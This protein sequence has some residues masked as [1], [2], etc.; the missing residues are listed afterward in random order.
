M[1][2]R[3]PGSFHRTVFCCDATTGRE[4][5]Q[6]AEHPDSVSQLVVTPDSKMAITSGHDGTIVF[7]EIETG[8][9][10][11]SL[12]NPRDTTGYLALSPDG[13]TLA[14]LATPAPTT[15][16]C[17]AGTS[18]LARLIRIPR[19]PR[20]T[21]D[22]LRIPFNTRR[23]DGASSLRVGRNCRYPSSFRGIKSLVQSVQS[24]A[25][26]DGGINWAEQSM[27]G[28][29]IAVATADESIFL[30]ETAT[31]KQRLQL[32]KIG[33]TTCLTLSPDGAFLPS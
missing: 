18:P 22:M 21:L 6:K 31:G 1:A 5:W 8:N 20:R 11:R 13:R 24:S 10:V 3:H 14:A 12:T 29:S 17:A 30:W 16:F 19:C 32:K 15:R 28:R 33:Y 26:M 9:V 27:D 2:A 23:T 7:W 25:L 4:F